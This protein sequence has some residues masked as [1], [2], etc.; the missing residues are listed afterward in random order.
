MKSP[1]RFLVALFLALLVPH[2]SPAQD[3][4]PPPDQGGA[5]DQGDG[6]SASFQTFYDQLGSQGSWIQTD[7][8]GT[9]F[10]PNVSDPNWAPY[11]QGHW[12]YTDEGWAWASDEPWGWATY[13]YGRWINLDGVGWVWVPGYQWA[14]AWVSWRHG[15][16]YYGWAPLPPEAGLDAGVDFHF[17]DDV[18][19]SFGIGAGWYN[20]CPEDR[21]GD[22]NVGPYIVNRYRNY[23]IIGRTTNIT[24]INIYHG[25]P[26]FGAVRVEGP[27]LADVNAHSGHRFQEVQLAR[28]DSVG[29]GHV[30]GN[31]FAVYAPRVDPAT[32]TTAHPANISGNLGRAEYNRGNSIQTPLQVTRNVHPAAATASEI[33]AAKQAKIPAS[34]GVATAKTSKVRINAAAKGPGANVATENRA[35][36]GNAEAQHN[37]PGADAAFT[38]GQHAEAAPAEH[39]EAAPADHTTGADAAFTGGGQHAEAAPAEHHEAAPA[40]HHEAAPSEEHQT[41]APVEHHEAAP[42]EHH[43][44]APSEE[45]QAAAP[46]EHH[47]AAPAQH[48]AAAPAQHHDAAPQ[49]SSPPAQHASGGN[50]SSGNNNQQK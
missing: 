17:G 47:E 28:A 21:F 25:R 4:P 38:G 3:Q 48:Q 30:E 31:R 39:H 12:V 6:P 2:L 18:D 34:A 7:N 27:S 23:G 13:H 43:E 5:P 29:P 50:K 33:R 22:P 46:V 24:N 45:H 35:A 10:Q 14:P 32:R 19:V 26:G 16:G 11:T 8:Y 40:E 42:V 49:H 1:V 15:G 20:F 41:A 44:A 9:V 37:T 36:T